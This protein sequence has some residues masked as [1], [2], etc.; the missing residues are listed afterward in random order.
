MIHHVSLP[1]GNPKFVAE[2]LARILGGEA[3]PFPVITGA[4]IAWAGDG[5]TEIEV[6]AADQGYQ[7]NIEPGKEPA[8]VSTKSADAPSGRHVAI[9]TDVHDLRAI[10]E[11]LS[12]I[13]CIAGPPAP[14]A[15][16]HDCK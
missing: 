3:M 4:W 15:L 5:V 6:I 12:A 7:P 13:P 1:A 9:S 8:I 10:Y 14:S 16:H 2:T 11:Y